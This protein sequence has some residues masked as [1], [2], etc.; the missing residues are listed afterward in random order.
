MGRYYVFVSTDTERSCP[1]F[2]SLEDAVAKYQA[3]KMNTLRDSVFL[4]YEENPQVCFDI[5]HKFFKDNVLINDY[6][7]RDDHSMVVPVIDALDIAYQFT[8]EILGGVLIDYNTRFSSYSGEA[9]KEWNEVY[10]STY[11]ENQ[12]NTVGWVKPTR[13]TLDRYGWNW[14][15]TASYISMMNVPVYDS[16]GYKHDVDIDPRAYLQMLGKK[17]SIAKEVA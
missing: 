16:H 11:A 14:P 3:T 4:G 13:E 17:V 8:H 10:L 1:K 7:N 9:K 12:M 6:L 15:K 2:E 5:V